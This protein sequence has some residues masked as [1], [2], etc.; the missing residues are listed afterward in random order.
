MN[1]AEPTYKEVSNT[2]EYIL[3]P[4]EEFFRKIPENRRATS[5]MDGPLINKLIR[6]YN[7][8]NEKGRRLINIFKQKCLEE[9]TLLDPRPE[10]LDWYDPRFLTE[11][12]DIWSRMGRTTMKD[13]STSCTFAT[14]FQALFELHNFFRN[15]IGAPEIISLNN[16]GIKTLASL[17]ID[18]LE[19]DLTKGRKLIPMPAEILNTIFDEIE[20]YPFRAPD[21]HNWRQLPRGSRCSL[22]TREKATAALIFVSG[23]RAAEWQRVRREILEMRN[24]VEV[25]QSDG[26]KYVYL[27]VFVSRE[28]KSGYTLRG[29][30][31]PLMVALR[32]EAGYTSTLIGN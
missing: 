16:K 19:V 28:K 2:L 27:N 11:S 20:K 8:P 22:K 7:S 6:K 29:R 12:V 1:L 13:G 17:F 23:I 3:T 30:S 25:Q 31:V 26:R 32:T 9:Y 14:I 21:R 5:S 4:D 15:V 24:T 18:R 10:N